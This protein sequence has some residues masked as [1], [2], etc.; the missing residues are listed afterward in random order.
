MKV[1]FVQIQL[2]RYL[3]AFKFDYVPSLLSLLNVHNIQMDNLQWFHGFT[4]T[5]SQVAMFKKCF[6][7]ILLEKWELQTCQRYL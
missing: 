6:I 5:A 7:C 3:F 4:T 1:I 2:N